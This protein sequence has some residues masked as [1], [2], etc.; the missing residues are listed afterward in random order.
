MLRPLLAVLLLLSLAFPLFLRG[1]EISAKTLRE[2]VYTAPPLLNYD[3]LVELVTKDTIEPALKAKLDELVHTP[4]ISN[5]FA[6]TPIL[7]VSYKLGKV[8]R[9]AEW[10]IE[11]G[12][13]LDD[14]KLALS[15][16]DEYLKK[17]QQSNTDKYKPGSDEYTQLKADLSII[18][19]ADILVLNEVDLGVKRTGY[20]NVARGLAEALHMNYVYGVEFLEV[21]P[22]NLGTETFD[23]ADAKTREMMRE[24]I[25]V[26]RDKFRG[27]HGSAILSRYPILSATVH[28]FQHQGYDWYTKEKQKVSIAE[29]GRREAADK[30]F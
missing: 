26:D 30:I 7:P 25:T 1:P 21:D 29:K 18:H 20:R 27:L 13:Q 14:I 9:V 16:P 15:S 17:V 10:N 23:E 8:V 24:K 2:P 4:F 22:I 3:D 12:L 28:P 19:N 5:E 11:R 6:N